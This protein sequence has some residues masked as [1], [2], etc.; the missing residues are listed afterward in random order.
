MLQ[1]KR[2]LLV[3]V[4][5]LFALLGL[6]LLIVGA[7]L[8]TKAKSKECDPPSA[9]KADRC[10]YSAEAKRASVD[11]FL[12][13][14][15]DKYYELH[16][17]DLIFKPGGVKPEQLKRDFKPYNPDPKNLKR[18]SDAARELLGELQSLGVNARQLKPREKKALAQVK[19][20]LE[21]NFGTPFDGDYYAGDF[22]MGPNLFCWQSICRVGTGDVR[23]G[24]G[25]LHTKDLS[26]VRLVLDKMKLFAQTF[27]QYIDN[28]KSGIKAGMV[29]SYEECI[30]GI[31]S[32]KRKYLQVSL[33]GDTG[34][35]FIFTFAWIH[36]F[37]FL[38][39]YR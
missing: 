24:L 8:L 29:R 33:K 32:F 6:I 1:K 35:L 21:N 23:Y 31:N 36:V 28:L 11:E 19:H 9:A 12:Q 2:N 4:A 30:A 14:V 16:P 13:K 17:Q 37:R 3:I 5:G 10:S 34:I 27:S 26:D 18:I 39:M 20:Y 15:Q 38:L 22:L 7:V 25:N